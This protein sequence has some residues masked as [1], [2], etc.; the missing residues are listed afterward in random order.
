MQVYQNK[1]ILNKSRLFVISSLINRSL[2]NHIPKP[3][4]IYS[5]ALKTDQ[6]GIDVL[7]DPLWNK[8]TAFTEFER[9]R[10]GLRGLLP[11]VIKTL[12]DQLIRVKAQLA[13]LK[14]NVEKVSLLCSVVVIVIVYC[15][16]SDNLI[17]L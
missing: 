12:E 6:F 15:S 14:D 16:D 13:E 2:A 4:K 5:T 11:P 1:V 9:D 7:H 10:L 3:D 17:I 8:G